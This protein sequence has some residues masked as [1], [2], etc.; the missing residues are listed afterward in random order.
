MRNLLILLTFAI[1]STTSISAQPLER[2]RGALTGLI[3]DTKFPMQRVFSSA[4]GKVRPRLVPDVERGATISVGN[5]RDPRI[6]ADVTVVLVE[7]KSRAPYL[8][9]DADRDGTIGEKDRFVFSPISAD[10]TYLQAVVMLPIKHSTFD[11]VPVSVIYYRDLQHPSLKGTDRLVSQSV[12][13]YSIGKVPI[14]GK[15]VLFQYPFEAQSP[16]IS[17]K[18]G[19]FGIDV[20]GDGDI[21]NEQF[22]IETSYAANEELVFRYGDKYLSTETIDTAKN[23]I[24]VRARDKSEYARVELELGKEMPD[25]EFVDFE[26]KPRSLKEFRGRYLL[27]EFWGVWCIDCVRDMPY[28]V[29]A[30]ERFRSRGFELLGLNWDDNVAE[31]KSFLTKSKAPWTQ[32]RKD[33]IKRLTE[34][35][36]RI[37]EYPSTLL[38]GPDGKV[39]VLDQDR[40]QGEMLLRTLDQILPKQ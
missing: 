16:T 25:F 2:Y 15:D 22:S 33:S 3:A 17:T 30:Y 38:L 39:L 9:V 34:V 13:I 32:A 27:I 11:A 14:N 29:Q 23:E 5:L 20:N 10:S 1:A 21:Y 6:N 18:E 31:A 40:I 37:Q 8:G 4:P 7:P 24:V 12:I 36:Y 28:N 19:L 26:G 35:T